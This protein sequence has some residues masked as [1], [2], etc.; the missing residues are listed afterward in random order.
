MSKERFKI[1]VKDENDGLLKSGE[2]VTINVIDTPEAECLEKLVVN[3]E[4]YG[5]FLAEEGISDC[6]FSKEI[7]AMPSNF[8]WMISCE[9]ISIW[10]MTCILLL[11]YGKIRVVHKNK[12][13][14]FYVLS[15]RDKPLVELNIKEKSTKANL[16]IIE[17]EE[18][19]TQGGVVMKYCHDFG[20]EIKNAPSFLV[21]DFLSRGKRMGDSKD[22]TAIRKLLRDVKLIT[23]V[24]GVNKKIEP[25]AEERYKF[26]VQEYK[27]HVRKTKRKIPL[28]ISKI[29]KKWMAKISDEGKS[30]KY[31]FSEETIRRDLKKHIKK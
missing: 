15:H 6:T 18:L 12:K 3:S 7:G 19:T 31:L 13:K 26:V 27:D 5:N 28:P 10:E 9:A 22:A 23:E 25:I 14:Y 17:G 21:S 1:S 20:D 16:A 29:H 30:D 4:F 11:V 2:R 8:T 24:R